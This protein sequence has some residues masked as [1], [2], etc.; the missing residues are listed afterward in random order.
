MTSDEV[1]SLAAAA[2]GLWAFG[3]GFGL[4]IVYFRKFA[5]KI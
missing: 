5:D 1:V 3:F 2:F 4:L